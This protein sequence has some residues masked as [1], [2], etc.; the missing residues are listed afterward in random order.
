MLRRI[1][2]TSV[3]HSRWYSAT[4]IFPTKTKDEWLASLQKRND[5]GVLSHLGFKMVDINEQGGVTAKVKYSY[6]F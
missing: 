3:L 2:Q 1:A 6:C 4:T 5:Y